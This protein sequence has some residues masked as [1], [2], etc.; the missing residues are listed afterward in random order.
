M[1]FQ[2]KHLGK[3]YQYSSNKYHDL[4]TPI[5]NGDHNVNA[6]YLDDPRFETYKAGDFVGSVKQ[7]GA[8]NCETITFNAHGNGTHTECVGHISD[9]DHTINDC[10]KDFYA[11]AQLISVTPDQKENGDLFIPV[12]VLD[13]VDLSAVEAVVIRTLPNTDSKLTQRYSGSNPTYLDPALTKK[14]ADND[15]LHVIVDVPSVDREEDGGLLL[16][17]HAFWQYPES[18]RTN[19]TITELAYIPNAAKDDKYLLHLSI[20]AFASDA[21]PSKPLLYVI[22]EV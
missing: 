21:S 13:N 22:E 20:A 3:T 2:F 7:G 8:C 14:L 1:E 10:L 18:P 5:A 9:Q 4:S 19:A 16:A 12:S 6:Y 17:H 11:M 15:V